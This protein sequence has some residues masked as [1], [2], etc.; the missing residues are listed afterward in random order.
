MN[1]C[2]PLLIWAGNYAGCKEYTWAASTVFLYNYILYAGHV[3]RLAMC[4]PVLGRTSPII[5][6]CV[7]CTTRGQTSSSI[8][9]DAIHKNRGGKFESSTDRKEKNRKPT[10][11]PIRY[12]SQRWCR[13]A[14]YPLSGL[15]RELRRRSKRGSTC[16]LAEHFGQLAGL[17][18][19]VFE[20]GLPHQ[21][22]L[23]GCGIN[24]K[25]IWVGN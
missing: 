22:V 16:N 10:N 25:I 18:C 21:V 1:A 7:T 11:Q 2:I 17:L 13:G 6:G 9:W 3:A 20:R 5:Q 23:E 14:G 24:W 8:F 4:H 19:I 12:N 15:S